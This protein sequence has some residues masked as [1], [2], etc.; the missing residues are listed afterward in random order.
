MPYAAII[1]FEGL[2]EID[3]YSQGLEIAN[4]TVRTTWCNSWGV[5]G[6]K[7]LTLD[8]E[9]PISLMQLR[10]S[11]RILAL[12]TLVRFKP[13][14]PCQT[15][16]YSPEVFQSHIRMCSLLERYSGNCIDN[17]SKFIPHMFFQSG[18]SECRRRRGKCVVPFEGIQSKYLMVMYII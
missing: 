15:P 10:H 14:T 7:G 9:V 3:K 2:A 17:F 1:K 4:T 18:C 11:D 13:G 12:I 5:T 16:Q 6:S 8:V